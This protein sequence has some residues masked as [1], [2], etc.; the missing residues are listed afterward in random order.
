MI[1]RLEPLVIRHT[2]R[3]PTP[4]GPVGE[5]AT[6]A[7][8]FDAALLSV[9]FKLSP[10]LLE[11]LSGL[12]GETVV[13]IAGRTLRTVRAMVG[14]H[15]QHNV[16]F[17]DFPANVPDTVDFWMSCVAAALYDEETSAATLKQLRTGVV[18]L[19]DLPTY[20]R[21]QH[22]YAEMLTAQDELITAAGDR[23]TVL[24]PGGDLA[25]ELTA[26][27]VQLAGSVTPL[28]EEHLHDLRALAERCADGPQPE[29]IP[30]R[31]NRAV[32][33]QA[34]LKV[35][36]GLL[37]DTVTD[38]LRL[39]CAL[40]DGDVTLAEPTRFRS[41]SRPVRRALLSGLDSVVAAAP[42]KLADVTAHREE[43][44]R[45]GERLHPHEYPKWPHAAEVFA[46]ARGELKARSF[47]GRVE[48]LLAENDVLGAVK[49]L[50]SA[51]GKL[52]RA[53]DRLLR[54]AL[55]QEERDAVVAAAEEVAPEVSGRVVLSV[56]EHL[57]NRARETGELRVFV[58]RRGRAWVADDER[59]VVGPAERER[60]IAALDDETRRRLP[61][62]ERLLV[63]PE[64]L[65]VALPLSG[66]A[67]A[68]GL[69]VLP[70][71]SVSAVEGELLRFFVYWKE[72][73][74]RTDFDL[75]ALM[76]N[77][78]YSTNTWLSYTSLTDVEGEHS[79][80]IV[81][82]P[83]GASEF[84]DLR[85]GAVRGAFVVP[86][87]NIFAGEGFE[88]VEESF[89]GFMLREGEQRGRPFE[90][91]TVRMKSELRG[92]GR[93]ALP[94][95]FQRGED[96]RWRAKWLHLYLKGSPSANRVEE[97][98]VTVANLLR[99]IVE[100]EQL[101]VGHLVELMSGE[102]AEVT[103]WEGETVPDDG[104]VT[105]IGL[106][107]PDGLPEGSRIVTLE[108]LRDLIPA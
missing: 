35:G 72:S 46:V 33:N 23:I 97:N 54:T 39:A 60:L 65:D 96:G 40:S 12:A 94:L 89:F 77:A 2:L 76:L 87:V 3:V 43:W 13:R 5:G 99:G 44:K 74:Q 55:T 63:D 30:V 41:L 90:P 37:L 82:A 103:L 85:L 58:N 64:V 21:Y 71:G 6:V 68:A 8:Q 28:G 98:R 9:G 59:T 48:E 75:S 69:G 91:R 56:R 50:R 79:G 19:L 47:D 17:L 102:A 53:L 15:V 61:S 73:E 62:A 88:E 67:T 25:D 31:E 93:V 106:R 1:D 49:L 83:D 86:Q 42:A 27:Y 84:I 107:R 16:Y 26:L 104:P 38:V 57:H 36:S 24:H 14:D 95:V 92:A 34:R 7:R 18:N 66:K 70:R 4:T 81:E 20:G 100:R 10:E 11:R 29:A 52:F 105:Y 45:L 78:D 80:D 32:V 101:T 51:P 22:T 108:N